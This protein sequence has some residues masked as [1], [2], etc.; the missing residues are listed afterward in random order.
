[1]QVVIVQFG[2]PA[3]QTVPLNGPQWTLCVGVGALTLLVRAALR[4]VPVG[5]EDDKDGARGGGGDGPG[6][7]T[8]TSAAASS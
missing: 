1:M 5:E 3:F 7:P 8:A 2:G 4:L 6:G